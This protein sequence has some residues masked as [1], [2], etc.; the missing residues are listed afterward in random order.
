MSDRLDEL[1]ARLAG[2][3][4]DRSLEGLEEA[5]GHSIAM[6]RRDAQAASLMAPVRLGSIGLALV[7]GVTAGAVATTAAIMTPHPHGVFSSETH[8]APSSLIEGGQ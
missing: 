7:M 4:T 3:P 6:R 5:L 2:S 8:L 1:V